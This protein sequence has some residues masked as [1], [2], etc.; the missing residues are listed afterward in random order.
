M[1]IDGVLSDAHIELSDSSRNQGTYV[2]PSLIVDIAALSLMTT[3][4]VS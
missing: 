2:I 4:Y 1:G 3:I